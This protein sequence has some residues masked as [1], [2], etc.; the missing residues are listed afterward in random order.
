MILKSKWW[1]SLEIK[2]SI[3]NEEV[4]NLLNHYKYK[5]HTNSTFE[6]VKRIHGLEFQ[7]KK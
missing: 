4:K 1:L 5:K 6:N 7:G 2:L 3:G